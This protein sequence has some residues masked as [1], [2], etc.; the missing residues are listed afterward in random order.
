MG[1]GRAEENRGRED[2]KE[3]FHPSPCIYLPVCLSDQEKPNIAPEE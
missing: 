2:R 1:Q 3:E